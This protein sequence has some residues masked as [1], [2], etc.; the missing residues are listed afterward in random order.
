[1]SRSYSLMII[2]LSPAFLWN[3]PLSFFILSKFLSSHHIFRMLKW[4]NKNW[5]KKRRC[6][7]RTSTDGTWWWFQFFLLYP[8]LPISNA[9]CRG[10]F[11]VEWWRHGG[12]GFG[13]SCGWWLKLEI[14]YLFK[15]SNFGMLKFKF[16][17]GS[18]ENVHIKWWK[19]GILM[20]LNRDGENRDENGVGGSA[21]TI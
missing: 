18:D 2:H 20:H 13:D 16:F 4:L 6:S 14:S 7:T 11:P 10:G 5:I 1:M 9:S 3:S 15:S 8:S 17:E 12:F 21:K 19:W